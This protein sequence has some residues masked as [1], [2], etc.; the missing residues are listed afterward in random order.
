MDKHYVLNTESYRKKYDKNKQKIEKLKEEIQ[1]LEKENKD[2]KSKADAVCYKCVHYCKRGYNGGYSE[3]LTACELKDDVKKELLA[4]A[5]FLLKRPRGESGKYFDYF[6]PWKR[7][8]K[9]CIYYEERS[10]CWSWD[11]R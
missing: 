9:A 4:N 7:S 8:Y 1:L 5:G 2:N 6:I 11:M 10:D 3:A